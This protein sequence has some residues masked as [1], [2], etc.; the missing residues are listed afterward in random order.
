M[1][2]KVILIFFSFLTL[3]AVIG[4]YIYTGMQ[5]AKN[6]PAVVV[7]E[8]F[9]VPILSDE[10]ISLTE[11]ERVTILQGLAQPS[12]SQISEGERSE[13]LDGLESPSEPEL[14]AEERRQILQGLQEN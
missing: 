14:T 11:E 7:E 2:N 13:I 3:A 12:E 1:P 9:P 10:P 5:A 4:V 8:S 6:I